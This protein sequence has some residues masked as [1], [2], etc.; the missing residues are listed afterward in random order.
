MFIQHARILMSFR[1][2][3][4]KIYILLLPKDTAEDAKFLKLWKER[5]HLKIGEYILSLIKCLKILNFSDIFHSLM[6]IDSINA[7]LM[8][9][10][11]SYFFFLFISRYCQNKTRIFQCLGCCRRFSHLK[12]FGQNLTGGPCCRLYILTKVQFW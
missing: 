8:W 3:D 4:E 12:K 2:Y 10:A 6:K 9:S 7:F 1:K 5:L 11:V